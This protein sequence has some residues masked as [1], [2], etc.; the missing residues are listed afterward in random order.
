MSE[1]LKVA[2]LGAS[3]KSERYSNMAVVLLREKGHEVVPVNPAFT[4]IEGLK[5]CPD[6]QSLPGDVHTLT[7]YVGAAK[8]AGLAPDIL[9]LNPKRVIF[10]PG[11]ENPELQK[12]LAAAGVEVKEACTLVLLRTGQFTL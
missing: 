9:K 12:T 3:P 6:I 7:M 1:S 5:T 11:S 10:N 8:S 2:V 4:E